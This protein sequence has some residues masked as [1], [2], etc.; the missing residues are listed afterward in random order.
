MRWGAAYL[1]MLVSPKMIKAMQNNKKSAG[2]TK[3][4]KIDS[5]E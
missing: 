5:K 3:R 1:R 2:A 4:R